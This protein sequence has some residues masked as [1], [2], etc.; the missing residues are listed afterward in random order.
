MFSNTMRKM[1]PK[2]DIT[3][4]VTYEAVIYSK[5]KP[6]SF[7]SKKMKKTNFNITWSLLLAA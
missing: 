1:S 2:C 7:R 6:C 5:T 3:P 4:T